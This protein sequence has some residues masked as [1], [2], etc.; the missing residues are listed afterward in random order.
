[1]TTANKQ[2]TGIQAI[3]SANKASLVGDTCICPS[4]GSSFVKSHYQQAFC[5]N[6]PGTK[7]KDKYWN[8]VDPKKRNNTTRISPASARWMAKKAL[9]REANKIEIDLDREQ[10]ELDYDGSWDAHQCYVERCEWC[11]RFNCT[12][13]YH[14]V[15]D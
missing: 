9:E 5:K 7:C 15:L 11:G 6:K 1:M 2:K 4:C 14:G 8:T 13:E 10:M 12:C 3:Y